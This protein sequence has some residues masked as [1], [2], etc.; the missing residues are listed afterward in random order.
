[1][2][3]GQYNTIQAQMLFIQTPLPSQVLANSAIPSM[4]RI[5]EFSK[6]DTK[7]NGRSNTF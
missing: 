7:N 4:T 3:P 2:R 6:G 5:A 1:M